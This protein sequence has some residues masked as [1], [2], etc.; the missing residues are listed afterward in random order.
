MIF[1]IGSAKVCQGT[2]A[3]KCV[4]RC[5]ALV[6]F[7]EGVLVSLSGQRGSFHDDDRVAFRPPAFLRGSPGVLK[8]AY[9]RAQLIRR[10]FV[11][12]TVRCYII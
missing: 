11:W 4:Q 10:L 3:E 2:K 5:C 1:W 9:K 12:C 8:G 7:L 6:T